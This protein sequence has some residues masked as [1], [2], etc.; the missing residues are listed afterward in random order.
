MNKRETAQMNMIDT[1]LSYCENNTAAT[2]GI[3]A[4]A[5]TLAQARSKYDTAN[6]LN[7][8]TIPGTTGVTADTRQLREVVTNLTFKCGSGVTAYA[9]ATANNELR[10]KVDYS[11][12]EMSKMSKENF[13]DVSDTIYKEA[14]ANLATAGDYGYDNSDVT[15]LQ[16]ALGVYLPK[17]QDPR[18]AA[19]AIKT[20]NV[21]INQTIRLIIDTFF[22]LQLDN[23]TNTLLITKPTFHSNYFNARI[24]IDLPTSKANLTGITTDDVTQ[25]PIAGTQATIYAV[26]NPTPLKSAITDALGAYTIK[27]VSPGNYTVVFT[28]IGYASLTKNFSIKAGQTVTVSPFMTPAP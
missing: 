1:T 16:A 8:L 17:Q 15:A 28:S 11:I 12:P 23:M 18:Q 6:L 19:I 22:K 20:A 9:G 7:Q 10:K 2:A 4:F 24:I 25:L 27:P 13:D 21:Q 26:G 3:T 14:L 5:T